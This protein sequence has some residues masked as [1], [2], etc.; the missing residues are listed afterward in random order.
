MAKRAGLGAPE[1]RSTELHLVA[2]DWPWF[3]RVS[4]W[5]L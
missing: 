3:S 4:V 1:G 2:G 5:F